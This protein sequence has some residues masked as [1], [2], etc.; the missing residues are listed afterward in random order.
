MSS[1]AAAAT[2]EVGPKLFK[3]TVSEA[4]KPKK[5]R[6]Q[7]IKIKQ[8]NHKLN[9][10]NSG[11]DSFFYTSSAAKLP[12]LA[13]GVADGVGGW[14]EMGIDPSAFSQALCDEM[15]DAFTT[16]L[17]GDARESSNG[18]PDSSSLI[19]PKA[20]LEQA[21]NTILTKNSVEAGGTTA[22]V[23]VVS[24]TTGVLYTAN[25]GDSGVSVYRSGRIVAQSHAQTHAFNTPYQLAILPRELREFEARQPPGASRHILDYPRDADTASFQ[26]QHGDLV[27]FS[28]DGFLDNVSSTEALAIVTKSLLKLRAWVS[29]PASGIA[30]ALEI[31]LAP[32]LV[33]TIAAQLVTAAHVAAHDV[34][35]VTPFAK[36]VQREMRIPYKGGKPDDI[37]IVAFYVTQKPKALL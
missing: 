5:R 27:V 9:R 8:T 4:Y 31:E 25:L 1:S 26:L 24:N 23:G 32:E 17:N 10:P 33:G 28:T 35:K 14:T 7:K 15:A 6:P 11:E 2:A 36:E 3:F 29:H 12:G 34:N 30:P 20:L 18:N 16:H 19:P 22:C 13:L 21:Y 37:T